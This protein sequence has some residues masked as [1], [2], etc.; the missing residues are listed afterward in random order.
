MEVQRW[1]EFLNAC[2]S[3]LQDRFLIIRNDAKEFPNDK[4]AATFLKKK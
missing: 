3:T 2:E 1:Y 4:E